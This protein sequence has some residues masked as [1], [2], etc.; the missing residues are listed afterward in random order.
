MPITV[1]LYA[2][3]EC[4]V[5]GHAVVLSRERTLLDY[6]IIKQE[7]TRVVAQRLAWS[8]HGHG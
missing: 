2:T 1:P 8:L 5:V 6:V 3:Q 7:R 4:P